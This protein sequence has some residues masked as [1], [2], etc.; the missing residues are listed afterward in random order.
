MPDADRL[1]ATP[2]PSQQTAAQIG[3]GI[4][5]QVAD[6]PNPDQGALWDATDEEYRQ[7]FSDA[8]FGVPGRE[9]VSATFTDGYSVEVGA[10]GCYADVRRQIWG[11]LQEY[12]ER[13]WVSSQGFIA[14]LATISQDPTWKER[15]QLWSECMTAAGY[16]NLARPG[17]APGIVLDRIRSSSLSGISRTEAYEEALVFEREMAQQD[18]DC[19]V[20]TGMRELWINTVAST[21]SDYLVQNHD[22]IIALDAKVAS[23]AAPTARL[24]VAES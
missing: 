13:S 15:V 11:D 1:L 4:A 7:S 19:S 24:A 21:N 16:P 9:V 22:S 6:I 2:S 18:A 23:I 14:A 8:L 17:D 12:T 20:R 10:S 5:G 3:Y